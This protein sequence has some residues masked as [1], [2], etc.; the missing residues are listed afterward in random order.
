MS[1][2]LT[3]EEVVEEAIIMEELD[4]LGHEVQEEE[5]NLRNTKQMTFD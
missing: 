2:Y 4:E 5:S 3:K 1:E